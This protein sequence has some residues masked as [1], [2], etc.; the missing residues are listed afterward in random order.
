MSDVVR[1]RSAT[2]KDF[3][4][5]LNNF[6]D[7]SV[8]ADNELPFLENLEFTPRGALTSRPPIWSPASRT[9]PEANV[10]FDLLGYFI[11]EDGDRFAVYTSPTKTYIYNLDNTWTQIWNQKAADF[12][13]YQGYII[14]C[15]TNGAGAS[16]AKCK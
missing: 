11:E 7:E 12:V 6:W 4:G 8:I 2:L 3:S 15:R 14:M 16:W 5:G 9:L 10:H 1:Q 13:Q